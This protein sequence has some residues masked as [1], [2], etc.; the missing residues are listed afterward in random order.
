MADFNLFH[1]TKL[2]RLSLTEIVSRQ[3]GQ[4][5]A[6]LMPKDTQLTQLTEMKIKAKTTIGESERVRVNNEAK[7]K[8]QRC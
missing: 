5:F 1:Y 3:Q 7:S 8:S 2:A 6:K 4:H